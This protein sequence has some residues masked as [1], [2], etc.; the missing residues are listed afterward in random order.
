LVDAPHPH[1]HTY[2]TH[3]LQASYAGGIQIMQVRFALV[4]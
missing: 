4:S 1:T 2:C 3:A